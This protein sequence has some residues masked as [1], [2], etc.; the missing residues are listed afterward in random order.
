[1]GLS[2]MAVPGTAQRCL[3]ERLS[4]R[5]RRSLTCL[6]LGCFLCNGDNCISH[7]LCGNAA[8]NTRETEDYAVLA[9]SVILFSVTARLID[10]SNAGFRVLGLHRLAKKKAVLSWSNSQDISGES[11][12]VLSAW[13]PG[14]AWAEAEPPPFLPVAHKCL[15]CAHVCELS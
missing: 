4:L 7:G 14:W 6:C 8:I 13:I 3:H 12:A 9:L 10:S 5:C 15:V 2:M 1:M 11:T